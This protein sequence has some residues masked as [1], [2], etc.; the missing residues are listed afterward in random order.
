M[1]PDQLD[2]TIRNPISP[3]YRD[4][5]A[6]MK[7]EYMEQVQAKEPNV[8]LGWWDLVTVYPISPNGGMYVS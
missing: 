5:W 6:Q 7:W 8:W 4:Q 2:K 3:E 1:T